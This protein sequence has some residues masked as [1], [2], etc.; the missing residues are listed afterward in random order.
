VLELNGRD[1]PG[2]LYDVGRMLT[3]LNLQISTARIATYGEQVVDVFYVKDLF[4]LKIFHE[5][6]L[7]EIRDKLLA[8]LIDPNEAD[9]PAPAKRQPQPRG[10][11]KAGAAD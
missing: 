9:K 7:A 3:G 5:A 6:K 8:A 1:R 2:L 10:G 11:A 4:G